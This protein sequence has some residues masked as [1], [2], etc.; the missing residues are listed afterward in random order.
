MKDHYNVKC[1]L[2]LTATA[3]DST[4]DEIRS[5]FD[6]EKPNIIKDCDLPQNL[7]ISASKDINKDKALVDLL[8][9]E[10][11]RPY[12]THVIV[13]C[14]RREQTE[15]VSHLLRLS[16]QPVKRKPL[17][18][19]PLSGVKSVKSYKTSKGDDDAHE[20]EVAEAYHAGLSGHQRKRIQNQFIKGK[21]RIIVATMAF[22]MGINMSNI[23]A[24]IH[25]NMP[26]SIENYVQEIGRAGRDGQLSRCHLFLETQTED[27]NEIKRYVHMNGYEQLTIKKLV[28]TIFDVCSCETEA[29][30][31]KHNVALPI[32]DMVDL[33]D[34]KEETILTLLCYLNTSGYI[35]MKSNSCYKT[36]FVRS[37]KG[38]EYL[39]QLAARNELA[40][41]MLKQKLA[42]DKENKQSEF[43]VDVMEICEATGQDY[44]VI[45]QKLK[46]LEWDSFSVNRNDNG[47]ATTRTKSGLTLSFQNSSFYLKRKCIKSG[48]QLDEINDYL[49]KRVKAQMDLSYSNFKALYK[50]LHENSFK[51]V[52]DYTESFYKS[53]YYL[54]L[55][56][57]HKYIWFN[58][59]SPRR[60]LRI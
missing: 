9:S 10:Q 16:M 11:F 31:F 52:D 26:K 19:L 41:L 12:S 48:D 50:M 34:I 42:Q 57:D 58:L 17:S 55:L 59:K 37:Y 38:P 21:L 2:G 25:Y 49:W 8:K 22:G 45:R 13:Y 56:I 28:I 47:M 32:S 20:Q 44:D 36:C 43:S 40:A 18:S 15:K 46:Q 35:E 39:V 5:Y 60:T 4:I 33:L 6:I 7:L 51:D 24:I 30:E 23:R 54:N 1:F 14:S 29:N 3:T 27:V 53:K